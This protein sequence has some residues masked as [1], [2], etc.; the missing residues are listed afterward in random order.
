MRTSYTPRNSYKQLPKQ[1][2]NFKLDDRSVTTALLPEPQP[3][4]H[5]DPWDEW[6]DN[7]KNIKNFLSDSTKTRQQKV[8]PTPPSDIVNYSESE[9][10]GYVKY[11]QSD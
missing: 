7:D 6:L 1:V 2:N 10:L 9:L 8:A 3:Q 4:Q 11:L 5:K